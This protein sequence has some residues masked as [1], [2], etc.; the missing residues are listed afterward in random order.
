MA[1]VGGK[2]G[3]EGGLGLGAERVVDLGPAKG[4]GGSF[5]GEEGREPRSE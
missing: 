3:G 4:T 2:L 5:Q 1:G